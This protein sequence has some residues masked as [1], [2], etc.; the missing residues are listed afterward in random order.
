MGL[1]ARVARNRGNSNKVE[2]HSRQMGFHTGLTVIGLKF[3]SSLVD[4]I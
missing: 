2:G 4:S 1:V 3:L